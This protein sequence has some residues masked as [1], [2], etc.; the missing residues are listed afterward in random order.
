M[1]DSFCNLSDMTGS[2]RRTDNDPQAPDQPTRSTHDDPQTRD[3]PGRPPSAG[4]EPAGAVAAIGAWA[5]RH[6]RLVLAGWLV[7]LVAVTLGHSAVSSVYSDTLTIPG[8]SAQAGLNVLRAHDPTAGGQSGQLV[9][10]DGQSKLSFQKTAIEQA[11]TNVSHLPHVLSVSDPLSKTTTSKDGH[12]AYASVNFDTNPQSLGSSYIDSVN[13]AVRVASNAGVKVTYGGALGQAAVPKANDVKSELIGIAVGLLV[14]LIGFG[15]VYAALLPLFSALVGVITGIGLL[16]I[17]AASISFGT[18]APTLAT[19]MGLGVGID[20]ALFVTTRHR[21]LLIDGEDPDLAIRRTLAASGRSVVIAASTV[22]IA[23]LG[24][25]A[26]GITF[27]GKLG[28]AAAITVAVAAIA[29]LTL[30]PAL[31]GFARSR[32]DR[33]HVRTPVAEPANEQSPLHAYTRVVAA[34]PWRFAVSGIVT[35]LIIAIPM[36]SMHLGHVGPGSEPSSYSERQAYE[37]ISHGFGAGANG[38]LTIVAQLPSTITSQQR[39]SLQSSLP[40][41][42]ETTSD[43]ESVSP[44]TTSGDNQ[45]L[46]G[47]VIPDSGP[48]TTA[49]QNLQTSLQDTVLPKA[50]SAD[51]ATGYV[52]GTT[53]ATIDFQNTVASR[54]PIIIGVVIVAAFLLL[55]AAFRS[56]VVA[57]K[58]ALLNL[59]SISAAYGVIVAVFQWGWGSSLLGVSGTVPI[60]SYVPMI[61]FAIVFGLSMDYE[62]FLISRIREHW[63]AGQDNQQ[64]VA[65]GLSQTA[66]V[67]TCAALILAIVF[68]AFLLS[69]SV[70]VKMLALGLGASV[71]IDATVIR[72]MI[73]PALMFLFDKANWWTPAWLE[74]ILPSLEPQPATPTRLPP[75]PPAPAP[76]LSAR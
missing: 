61:I 64:S 69:T 59:L 2:T 72:L 44:F 6:R 31:L 1:S 37:A 67:I 56:P 17:L 46:I 53:A 50:L 48:T 30:V 14:L 41:T 58:A 5:A 19:M 26:S 10:V 33:V 54:L 38:P 8:S 23:M 73:V 55:L 3:Q 15:S 34:H 43:V 9:F 35:L 68:F 57:I 51:H 75:P 32:I 40:Q 16:G 25:Y 49:T 74:R 65:N 76:E 52:T 60:E 13:N 71:I 29:A 70:V 28:L 18:S 63:L 11:T 62:V 45:L 20:Y 24:L 7:L 36:L 4:G 66:R 39:T 21:Q 27:I 47:K 42:L 12:T 22:V